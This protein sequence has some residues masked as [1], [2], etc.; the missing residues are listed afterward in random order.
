MQ[1]VAARLRLRRWW[2]GQDQQGVKE[3]VMREAQQLGAGRA[4]ADRLLRFLGILFAAAV[5]L[6]T[7]L[8]LVTFAMWLVGSM[9]TG[10]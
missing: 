6:T 4:L 10:L 1:I 9:R 3:I 2:H 8:A 5:A 7:L